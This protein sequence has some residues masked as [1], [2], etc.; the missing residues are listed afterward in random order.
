MD[1]ILPA[2]RKCEKMRDFF[3]LQPVLRKNL[4]CILTIH[5]HFP[6][7]ASGKRLVKTDS[8]EFWGEGGFGG[9]VV[10]HTFLEVVRGFREGGGGQGSTGIWI[11]QVSRGGLRNTTI[12][13]PPLSLNFGWRWG[14]R[15]ML[16]P[17]I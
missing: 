12:P 6:R 16:Y 5:L 7:I 4:S 2:R 10:F 17:L 14:V 3:V 13:D 8:F 1:L 11:R 9:G 15:K